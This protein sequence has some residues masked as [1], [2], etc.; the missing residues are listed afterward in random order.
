[1]GKPHP[2]PV[3]ENTTLA[4]V[5][6]PDV[7]YETHLP[8]SCLEQLS[9]VQMES[10][11]YAGQQFAGPSL[12]SSERRGVFTPTCRTVERSRILGFFVLRNGGGGGGSH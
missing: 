9:E 6:P 8:P 4:A 10:V 3:V 7:T 5:L 2:D 11:I 12:S 1:I